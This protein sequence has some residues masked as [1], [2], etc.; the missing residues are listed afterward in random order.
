MATPHGSVPAGMRATTVFDKAGRQLL[1]LAYEFNERRN[2]IELLDVAPHE[3]FY[4]AF[5]EYLD[6]RP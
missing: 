1:R 6:S 3:N 5:Q 4:P 2:A